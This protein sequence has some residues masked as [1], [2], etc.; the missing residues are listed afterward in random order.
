L[1][2]NIIL[3]IL[4]F[5]LIFLKKAIIKTTATTAFIHH[6]AA[7]G[8][9]AMDFTA[10]TTFPEPSGASAFVKNLQQKNH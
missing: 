8:N 3:Y 1:S 2:S 10:T 4:V 5:I 9:Q 6:G 7:T